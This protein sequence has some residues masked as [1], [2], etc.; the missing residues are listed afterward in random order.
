MQTDRQYINNIIVVGLNHKTAP[1]EVREKLAFQEH[2]I[3]KA[4]ENVITSDNIDETLILSTCNRVEIYAVGECSPEIIKESIVQFIS[5]FHNLDKSLFEDHLYI[6]KNRDAVKH[7]FRVGSSL[8]SI[9]VGEPQILGQLKDAY[10]IAAENKTT[11]TILNKLLHK[12]F[13]VAKKVRTETKISNSAVSISFAAVELAKKIFES[14]EDKKIL[15]IGA[16]EM[17]ELAARHLLSNGATEIYVANRTYDRAE[18]LAQEFNGEAIKF[19]HVPLFLEKVDIVISS[20]G[21]PHYIL[22]A[23]KVKNVVKVRK[24]KPIFMI[25]IAVPRDIDPEINNIESIYLYDIDDLR[26]V[27]EK[28]W[29]AR[30]SEAEKAELIVEQEADSFTD[31]MESLNV[32]PVIRNLRESFENIR[33]SETDKFLKKLNGLDEKQRET[34]IYLTTSII[35]KILHKPTV[36]LK[37]NSENSYYLEAIKKIFEL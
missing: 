15:L 21:A 25:D 8:D 19:E 17:C 31:W 2:V 32:V 14:F 6:L 7:I 5:D 3:E 34:V 29:E 23:D 27:V 1:V 12:A 9:V 33:Q 10:R 26:Q 22:T 18:T 30:K 37:K 16:G 24:Y 35:N 36:N 4:L 13:F 11:K 20:T 28:N